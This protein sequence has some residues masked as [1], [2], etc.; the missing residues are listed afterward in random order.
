[1]IGMYLF[2]ISNVLEQEVYCDNRYVYAHANRPIMK[3]V[4]QK[5]SLVS[6]GRSNPNRIEVSDEWRHTVLACC[7]TTPTPSSNVDTTI[8]L[9]AHVI[10]IRGVCVCYYFNIFVRIYHG[11]YP[12][13]DRHDRASAVTPS[14]RIVDFA[15]RL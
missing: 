15:K 3:S 10:C 4:W 7:P 12:P 5:P 6:H 1:M 2:Q 13:A 8:T 14:M 11:S 9:S